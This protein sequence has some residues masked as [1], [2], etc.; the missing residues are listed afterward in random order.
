MTCMCMFVCLGV[1]VCV[2]SS[3]SVEM[4]LRVGKEDKP[5]L[6]MPRQTT[7]VCFILYCRVSME[8]FHW[9]MKGAS[10]PFL[11]HLIFMQCGMRLTSPLVHPHSHAAWE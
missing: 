8:P 4:G 11:V 5:V 2:L 1:D 10:L 6:L 9:N 7:E 3:P